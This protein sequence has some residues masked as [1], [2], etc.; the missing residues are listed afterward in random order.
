MC[1]LVWPRASA[2]S[3]WVTGIGT[4]APSASPTRVS[5]RCSSQNRCASRSIAERRPTLA[6]HSR[7][8][9]VVASSSRH[10]HSSTAGRSRIASPIWSGVMRAT[11]TGVSAPMAWSM[12][13]RR[14][15]NGSHRSPGRSSATIARRPSGNCL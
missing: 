9:A 7:W 15:A 8:I 6:I 4:V 13:A 1:T 11:V 5:R 12:R 14:N 10:R 2:R 3:G